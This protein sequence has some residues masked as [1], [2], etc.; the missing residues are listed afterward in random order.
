MWMA[1][2]V[3]LL[4]PG[5]ELAGWLWRKRVKSAIRHYSTVAKL[6][7]D[8]DH[9]RDYAVLAVRESRKLIGGKDEW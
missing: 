7:K 3:L 6:T 5:L 2:P 1:V 8:P 4:I 9:A